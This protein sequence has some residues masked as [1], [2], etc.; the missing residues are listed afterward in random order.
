MSPNAMKNALSVRFFLESAW[1]TLVSVPLPGRFDANPRKM[2]LVG[3]TTR[4]APGKLVDFEDSHSGGR[5]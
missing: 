1:T 5:T 3:L 4:R 2:A